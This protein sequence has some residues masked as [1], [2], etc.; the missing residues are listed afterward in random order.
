MRRILR[1]LL[2]M[3]LAVGPLS[4]QE[5]YAV[6]LAVRIAPTGHTEV[7]GRAITLFDPSQHFAVVVTNI[8][9]K[10]VRLWR[11]WC[12]WGYFN[13][14]FEATDEKGA[15][16]VV[17]KNPREWTKNFPDW[18][19]IPPGDHM[20]VD[21]TFDATTWG[22]APLPEPGQ[23]RTVSLRA[24]YESTDGEDAKENK[25]WTGKV[26]SPECEYTLFR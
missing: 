9:K 1:G 7:G 16:V 22:S 21:V 15:R 20:V 24:V 11:E 2:L 10:P 17:R 23:N 8:G 26:S 5:G 6:A 4:A 13:L 12:S 14:Y 25:V 3:A 18:M 19:I